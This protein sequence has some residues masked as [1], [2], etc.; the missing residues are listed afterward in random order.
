MKLS[1]IVE[2]LDR[3]TSLRH[4]P[5]VSLDVVVGHAASVTSQH[6]GVLELNAF[7]LN[8]GREGTVSQIGEL[9]RLGDASHLTEASE[10]FADRRIGMRLA[11]YFAEDVV[12]VGRLRECVQCINGALP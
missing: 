11:V 3:G 10:R 7:T 1:I 12:V 5:R 4:H 2:H 8:C 6:S 9:D